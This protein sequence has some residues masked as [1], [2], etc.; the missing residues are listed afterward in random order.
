MQNFDFEC[1]LR[2]YDFVIFIRNRDKLKYFIFF[3][4]KVVRINFVIYY[5]KMIFLDLVQKDF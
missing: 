1:L 4:N 5:E 2:F 3:L